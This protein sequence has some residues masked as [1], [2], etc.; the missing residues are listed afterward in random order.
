[1]A[2]VLLYG[3][4]LPVLIFND[5]ALDGGSPLS[6]IKLKTG[7]CLPWACHALFLQ[8]QCL[9]ER[10]PLRM[11]NEVVAVLYL[12]FESKLELYSK[13]SLYTR[14]VRNYGRDCLTMYKMWITDM[15][16]NQM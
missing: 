9:F 13:C 15:A 8:F 14:L 5:K 12:L 11:P 3:F 6:H 1:M 10:A 16:I 2:I 4:L 7:L